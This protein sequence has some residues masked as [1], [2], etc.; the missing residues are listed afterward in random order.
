MGFVGVCLLGLFVGGEVVPHTL[1]IQWLAGLTR[2]LE[3]PVMQDLRKKACW[4]QLGSIKGVEEHLLGACGCPG[5][6]LA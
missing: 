4:A 1:H 5:L 2:A 3:S 6:C